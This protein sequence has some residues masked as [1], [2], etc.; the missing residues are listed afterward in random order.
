M[1][2]NEESSTALVVNQAVRPPSSSYDDAPGTKCFWDSIPVEVRD[3][4]FDELGLLYKEA[5]CWD[6]LKPESAFDWDGET[7]PILAAL[8]GLPTAHDHALQRFARNKTAFKMVYG[9][10]YLGLTKLELNAIRSIS[11]DIT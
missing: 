10:H 3:M 5:Y 11:V 9:V 8:R 2:H 4:I 7:P 1:R 6:E